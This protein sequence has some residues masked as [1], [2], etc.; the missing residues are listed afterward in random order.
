MGNKFSMHSNRGCFLAAPRDP[1]RGVQD[2]W[3]LRFAPTSSRRCPPR[4]RPAARSR[5][6]G[7]AGLRRDAAFM[8]AVRPP[9]PDVVILDI[10]MPGGT[11][12]EA[13]K[14]LKSS[15]NT[16]LI[17]VIIL[18]GSTDAEMPQK[19]KTLGADEFLRKPVDQGA[20][21]AALDKVL[22]RR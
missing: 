9:P 6:P 2:G 4:C 8:F 13:L 11:G 22:P 16:A 7:G 3:R 5:A 21:F 15:L 12:I 18:S 20:L 14:R 19:V 1:A 17:P 10:N